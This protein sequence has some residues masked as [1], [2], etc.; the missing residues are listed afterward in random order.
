[1]AR[2]LRDQRRCPAVVG[3]DSCIERTGPT[4]HQADH[5][6]TDDSEQAPVL[7]IA[8]VPPRIIS[9]EEALPRDSKDVALDNVTMD[10]Q[11]MFAP[12]PDS[13]LYWSLDFLNELPDLSSEYRSW[14]FQVLPWNHE[15]VVRVHVFIDGS[16]FVNRQAPE[17]SVAA[18]A[19][20]VIVECMDSDNNVS[21]R[22]L[23]ATSQEL[24]SSAG[25]CRTQTGSD[26]GKLDVGELLADALSAEAVG[27]IWAL[28]WFTQSPFACLTVFHYDNCTIGPFAAGMQQW[29]ATWEY[30]R[31]KRNLTALRHF[32]H[33]Q[34]RQAMF[35]HVKAHVGFPWSE[36][37]DS[38]AKATA[39]K[40]V[41]GICDVPQVPKALRHPAAL[42][43][44]LHF[45]DH[46]IV[47]DI[48][49]LSHVFN[50]EGPT[51][52]MIPADDTWIHGLTKD[53]IESVRLTL[54]FASANVLTLSGGTL[55][56]QEEG[57]LQMGRISTLQ[58]QFTDSQCQVIGLQECRTKRALSRH[59]SSHLVY[60]SGTDSQGTKGCEL[61][62]DR[63]KPYASTGSR[64]FFF[65]PNHVQVTSA[66]PRH[67]FV[68]IKAPHLCLRVLV[69]HAPHQSATDVT[70]ESWW[71]NIQC[72]INRTPSAIPLIVLADTNA[73]LGSITSDAIDGFHA[74]DE[75]TTGH[76]VAGQ[77]LVGTQH[78]LTLPLWRPHNMGIPFR[79]NVQTGL[80]LFA[81]RLEK[82]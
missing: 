25:F 58:R 23:C 65:A 80:C 79:S 60:Q 39:K 64:K 14:L 28:S 57:L 9:L 7:P 24:T 73:R 49:A 10:F 4:A 81:A 82:F 31:L 53:C 52:Q 29:H 45:S 50:A 59:S 13:S 3:I 2:S 16:S 41:L 30:Q 1:M 17:T 74:D 18:W 35:N 43:A 27:M 20:I 67:L 54:G 12:W 51:K 72:Q 46:A 47:P 33:A 37:V 36:A 44:W 38:L 26:S 34:N 78:I 21:Y 40:A 56:Q 66:D 22:F 71:Q 68:T 5:Y 62:L 63:A 61:W 48:K 11:G 15:P 55:K 77:F 70:H 8:D 76:H 32:H 6:R 69:L 42:F 19:F 75:S